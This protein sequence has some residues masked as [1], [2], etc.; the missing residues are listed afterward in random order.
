MGN[1]NFQLGAADVHDEHI[2]AANPL[3]PTKYKPSYVKGTN[4]AL[5]IGATPVAREEI[6][7]VCRAAGT[8]RSFIATLNAGGSSTSITFDLKV[9]GASVLTGVVTYT[10]SDGNRAIK[11]GTIATA[12]VAAGDV[13]SIAMAVSSST[14]AQGPYAELGIT[15]N[16]AP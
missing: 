2:D 1:I 13:V 3:G 10:N 14:G 15:E 4:F 9:N 12:P 11:T 5:A 8:I 7:H 6:V 16:T